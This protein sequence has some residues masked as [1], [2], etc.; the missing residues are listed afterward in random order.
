MRPI[1]PI[2]ATQLKIQ[3]SCACSGTWDWLM[4]MDFS[5]SMPEAMKPAQSS[6]V[7]LRSLAGSCQTVIACRST[8][9]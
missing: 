4:R 1:Q 7:L 6:R 2:R 9:Q 3:A 5:G 8:M